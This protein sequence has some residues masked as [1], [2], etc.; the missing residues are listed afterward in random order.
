M[1]PS[2]LRPKC[3][4]HSTHIASFL[5][6][7]TFERGAVLPCPDGENAGHVAGKRE[8]E[9]GPGAVGQQSLCCLSSTMLPPIL[10]AEKKTVQTTR[11]GE[12]P[13]CH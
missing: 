1:E 12:K 8:Q 2:L 3:T 10:R 13:L 9:L 6:P 4:R 11:V 7:E 5:L